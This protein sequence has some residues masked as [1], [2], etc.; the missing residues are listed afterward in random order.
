MTDR[1]VCNSDD[2][3]SMMSWADKTKQ[4]RCATTE[5]LVPILDPDG[6]HLLVRLLA[7]HNDHMTDRVL[8][9]AKVRDTM[10]PAEFM[11]DVKHE[12][13][14]ALNTPEQAGLA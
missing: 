4:N 14:E 6:T 5:E 8:V 3:Y 13:Y 1:K 9:F 10:I 2:L 12:H 11:L 7:F